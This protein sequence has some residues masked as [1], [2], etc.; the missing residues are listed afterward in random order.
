MVSD[1]DSKAISTK[2]K[3]YSDCTVVILQSEINFVHKEKTCS[4]KNYKFFR[5]TLPI[6]SNLLS[7][8]CKQNSTEI[9]M[10]LHPL[11]ETEI[12]CVVK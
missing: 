10:C 8:A 9:P 1:G 12:K 6:V 7:C 5:K 4:A 11:S 3:V 2:G